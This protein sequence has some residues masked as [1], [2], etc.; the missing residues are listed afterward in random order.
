MTWANKSFCLS[1]RCRLALIQLRDFTDF[2]FVTSKTNRLHRWSCHRRQS[3]ENNRMA[4]EK[5]VTIACN[6]CE[7]TSFFNHSQSQR[8]NNAKNCD[9]VLGTSGC[10]HRKISKWQHVTKPNW[11]I[12]DRWRVQK[13]IVSFVIFF[14]LSAAPI[15]MKH[16]ND[17]E[18]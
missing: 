11:N 17:R 12:Y 3:T 7:H 5:S 10:L 2:P 13:E 4:L 6:G 14:S 16:S 9:A 18:M 15:V 8:L 1:R